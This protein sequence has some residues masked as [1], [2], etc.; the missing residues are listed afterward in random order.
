MDHERAALGLLPQV[1]RLAG[2]SACVQPDS[3]DVKMAAPQ[4]LV[5]FGAAILIPYMNVFFKVRF[6]ISDSLLGNLIQSFIRDDRHWDSHRPSS[7]D[8]AGRQSPCRGGDPVRQSGVSV[9]DGLCAIVVDFRDRL[10]DAFRLDEHVCAA[11]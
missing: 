10:S 3:D 4:I 5:G 2:K 11:L 8:A 9:D 6:Q 7:C 1:E